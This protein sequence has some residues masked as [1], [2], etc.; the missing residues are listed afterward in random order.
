MGALRAFVYIVASLG[1][2]YTNTYTPHAGMGQVQ[3]TR[4]RLH[5][6]E[7]KYHYSCDGVHYLEF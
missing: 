2:C 7:S 6:K 5:R 1:V 4:M 3:V